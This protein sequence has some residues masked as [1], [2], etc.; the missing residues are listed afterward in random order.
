MW[1]PPD[2]KDP[3]LLHAPTRK[4]VGYFGAVRLR[5]GMFVWS[6]E[7]E[8]FDG[9]TFATFLKNLRRRAIRS[10]KKIVV[11]LDN[12]RFHHAKLHKEWRELYQEYFALMFLPP[13]SP[14]LNTIERTWKLA[15]RLCTHNRYFA[16]LDEVITAVEKQFRQWSSPNEQLR[17]LCSFT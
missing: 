7:T 17:R 4:S 5:D 2:V 3:V 8:T 1:I 10:Q 15:R 6:R 16:T 11:V 12:A 9:K 13:Y 14:E